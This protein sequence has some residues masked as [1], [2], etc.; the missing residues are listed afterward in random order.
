LD[1]QTRLA[2]ESITDDDI[3]QIVKD[4]E[5]IAKGIQRLNALSESIGSIN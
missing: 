2:K 3:K 4:F 5:R 1:I